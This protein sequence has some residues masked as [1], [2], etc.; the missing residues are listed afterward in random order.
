MRLRWQALLAGIKL[1]LRRLLQGAI[2]N[3]KPGFIPLLQGQRIYVGFNVLG[4]G[5]ELL[6]FLDS[7]GPS[8]YLRSCFGEVCGKVAH[9][10][11][12]EL[13]DHPIMNVLPHG[14]SPKTAVV[15]GALKLGQPAAQS[16]TAFLAVDA[17]RRDTFLGVAL[18]QNTAEDILEP[19]MRLSEI[20]PE[21]RPNLAGD[22]GYHRLLDEL[23]EEIEEGDRERAKEHLLGSQ[24]FMH[25]FGCDSVERY[26]TLEGQ[27][28]FQEAWMP[29]T[30]PE[31]SLLAHFL[32]N[33]WKPVWAETPLE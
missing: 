7:Q 29:G 2:R 12:V 25:K 28:S 5:W 13:A 24:T 20:R 11:K 26:L 27:R 9:S 33:V 31:V 15:Q 10:L 8:S 19:T 1:Y 3:P 22:I 23:W 32:T 17:D 21:Q 6:K 16:P 14:M 30:C 4:Q 18:R